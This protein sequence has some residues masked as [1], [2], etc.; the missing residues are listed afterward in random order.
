MNAEENDFIKGVV[1]WVDLQA[2]MWK[3]DWPISV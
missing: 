3:N 2:E 1:G